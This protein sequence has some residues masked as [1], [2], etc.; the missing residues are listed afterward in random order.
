[1]EIYSVK[2]MIA[3]TLGKPKDKNLFLKLYDKYKD[4]D[5]TPT[6]LWAAYADKGGVIGVA[7]LDYD[8]WRV[9]IERIN[10]MSLAD[11]IDTF[12]K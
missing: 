10:D 4:T 1:M 6:G 5:M 7:K 9:Q 12:V 2:H 8:Q 11:V 3:T